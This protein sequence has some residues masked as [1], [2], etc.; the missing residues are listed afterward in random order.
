[1]SNVSTKPQVAETAREVLAAAPE[2]ETWAPVPVV[3]EGMGELIVF[4]HRTGVRDDH[5]VKS[6][7]RSSY[8]KIRVTT[9]S[10]AV[11]WGVGH[12]LALGR[13]PARATTVRNDPEPEGSPRT[14]LTG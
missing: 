11:L 1:M 13:E 12:G 4:G 6:Y 10:Q 3:L 2:A 14:G 9:R 5:T 7:I 8:R